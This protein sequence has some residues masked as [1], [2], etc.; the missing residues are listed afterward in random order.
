MKIG[1]DCRLS[2]VAHAG[3][4]R[5][6]ENLISRLPEEAP[7]IE[8]VYFYRTP[9]Q[10]LPDLNVRYIEAPVQHYTFQEQLQLLS[11]FNQ[12]KLDLLHVPHFNVPIMYPGKLVVTIH[13]L[14]WHQQRGTQV[15]TQKPW[16][17]WGKYAGYKV[18]ATQAINK[19]GKILVPTETIKKTLIDHYP[20]T[21]SK[22]VIT[23]EGVDQKLLIY[24]TKQVVKQKN[25]LIYVGSLY[26]HKNIEVVLKSLQKLP[27]WKLTIVGSRNAFQDQVKR[28]GRKLGVQK[29]L[30]FTGYLT[31][32]KLALE[33]KTATVLV[34]PSLSEGFG[35]TGI[36]SMALGTPVIASDI[37]VFREIYQDAA[38][39]FNPKS[40]ESFIETLSK[41][42]PTS[43]Q[44][45]SVAE[46]YSWDEMT[47]KTIKAYRSLL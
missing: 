17:Y 45:D 1:I 34:Q 10:V 8:W 23:H 30:R 16:K 15:T 22:V 19:A 43:K 36:E 20:N 38:A 47:K 46:N 28:E 9:D 18:V 25:S 5:Y 39:Y 2:G 4:G 40:A 27:T 33:I 7:G 11:I 42:K 35:L 21:K 14:L 26:P 41:K 24:K 44:M 3:I 31:D 29:Q 6:I 37:P 32:E 13:D 12:E